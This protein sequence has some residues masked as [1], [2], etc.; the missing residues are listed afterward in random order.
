[1][2]RAVTE[3][4]AAATKAAHAIVSGIA[5]SLDLDAGYFWQRLHGRSDDPIPDISLSAA[6]AGV[7]GMGRGRTHRLWLSHLAGA[8]RHGRIA[9]EGARWM[10]RCAANSRNDRLQYRRHARTAD[11]RLLQIHAASR[12]ATPAARAACRFLSSS[13]PASTRRSI[14]CRGR[15]STLPTTAKRAGTNPACTISPAPMATIFWA[16]SPKFFPNCGAM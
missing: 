13:I 1:M 8:G 2:Q 4:M 5:L 12:A 15:P 9:G 10:D 7:R 11:R 16:R 6:A 3:Y 14:R